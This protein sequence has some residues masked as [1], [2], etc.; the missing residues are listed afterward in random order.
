M[1]LLALCWTL[2][3]FANIPRSLDLAWIGRPSAIVGTALV[4]YYEH[5]LN[6]NCTSQTRPRTLG[7]GEVEYVRTQSAFDA[8]NRVTDTE[9]LT[10][11]QLAGP[12]VA[13]SNTHTRVVYNKQGKVFTSTDGYLRVTTSV[14]DFTG[15]LVETIAPDGTVARSVYDQSGR[16]LFVQDRARPDGAGV[17]TGPAARNTYDAAGRVIKTERCK[18]IRLQKTSANANT[19]CVRLG[20]GA[21]AQVMMAVL[22]SAAEIAANVLTTTRSFYDIVGRVEYS[23]DARGNVTENV[24]DIAGRRAASIFYTAY[25]FDPAQAGAAIPQPGGLGETNTFAYDANGNQTSVTDAAGR[26]TTSVYDAGNRVVEVIFPAASGSGVSRRT[27]IYD[28]LGQ[29]VRETDEANVATAYAYDLRGSLSSVTVA[30]GTPQAARYSY[31]YDEAGNLT[32]QTD[33][34]NHATRFEYDALGRLTARFLPDDSVETV[35][36]AA[37][38]EAADSSVQVLKKTVTDFNGRQ[39]TVFHDR[40]DRLVT[41]RFPAITRWDEVTGLLTDYRAVT[42]TYE[43]TATGRR[44]RVVQSGAVNRTNSYAYDN[45]GNLRALRTPEGTLTYTKDDFGNIT[46]ITSRYTYTSW[47]NPM[48]AD[49]FA[50]E[51]L[52]ASQTTSNPNGAEWNYQYDARG[53]LQN[54]NPETASTNAVYEYDALGNLRKLTQGNG[55]ATTYTY[56]ERNWLRLVE[57]KR[58][59]TTAARFD[60]DQA[61][62][63]ATGWTAER[64][65][66]AAGQRQRVVELINGATRTVDYDY[67]VLKRLTKETIAGS[68]PT[69]EVRYDKV[70]SGSTV[71]GYDLVGNRSSRKVTGASLI[72]AGVLDYDAHDFDSR[73]QLK[74]GAIYDANGNT[75]NYTT[76]TQTASYI[77][78][79]ENRLVKQTG[80]GADVTIIYDADGNRVSKTAGGVTTLYLVDNQNPSGYAQVMEERPAATG[81]PTVTYVYGLA[82]VSQKRGTAVKYYGTDGLGSVRY[83][84]DSAGAI[85]DTYTHDAFGI[86]IAKTGTT[87]NDYRYTGQQ[88]DAD[89][90]MY[91][92]RARY[93]KPDTGRFWT[94]DSYEGSG[95]EPLSLHK[96]VYCQNN[97]VNR[98]DPSGLY[99]ARQG[100]EAE[101]VI[102]AIYVRDHPTSVGHI[103]GGPR[104]YY[105]PE[106]YLKPDIQNDYLKTYLEIK[107]LSESGILKGVAKL[108]IDKWRFQSMGY[109]PEA[110]WHPSSHLITV[111]SQQMVVFNLE[112]VVF[113]TDAVDNVED[114]LGLTTIELLKNFTKRNP[115]VLRT[116]IGGALDKVP[117]MVTT[118]GVADTARLEQCVG[119]AT[120]L[121]ILAL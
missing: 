119:I 92:L 69:G 53:R 83:L 81:D 101:R 29:K 118:R 97:A 12:W 102:M 85:T 21:E 58:G 25:V 50:Y 110:S 16:V 91:Y 19:N 3:G 96:Y 75:T 57:S 99:T 62:E 40:M 79:A 116:L 17:T 39:T 27:T 48:P 41:N 28:G 72:A 64:R 1:I 68:S 60:Y 55:V 61:A 56:N 7:N 121:T 100:Y 44:A 114:L 2:P 80:I 70:A 109:A 26:A 37:V 14:Y 9:I 8:Q 71:Q 82:L 95:G 42:N 63:G 59:A 90:G 111:G 47:P 117:G 73:D 84:T 36:Y 35:E 34:Q 98:M 22:S 76:G 32:R 11:S 51:T 112:G 104:L 115:Y 77:Y 13:V 86:S 113:Y 52:S 38:N 54:V 120:L 45:L 6:G 107:P 24:Y 78:D 87:L 89:L 93:Y 94:M 30:D 46:R 33:P 65:L 88:W 23:V 4:T 103:Y 105:Y 5:D 66:S 18:D 20:S 31:Q 106:D 108:A 74:T 67:D 43:Y 49:G 15:N 10:S